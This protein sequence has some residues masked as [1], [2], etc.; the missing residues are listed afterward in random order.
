MD[1]HLKLQI[2]LTGL[3]T[4]QNRYRDLQHTM[5]CC[6]HAH[7]QMCIMYMR[8]LPPWEWGEAHNILCCVELS[9]LLRA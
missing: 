4:V 2:S 3:D 9:P 1:I 8:K 7:N 6:A 5:K